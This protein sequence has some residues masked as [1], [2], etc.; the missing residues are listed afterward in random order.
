[1]SG[2][3]FSDFAMV[4]DDVSQSSSFQTDP[5]S[6]APPILRNEN[7]TI[8]HEFQCSLCCDIP[9]NPVITP[10]A[11]IFFAAPALSRHSKLDSNAPTIGNLSVALTYNHLAAC[12]VDYGKLYRFDVPK[13]NVHGLETWVTTR[14]MLVAASVRKMRART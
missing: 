3:A 14:H 2:Y 11:N 6:I 4:V 8:Q 9:F 12:C 1:M 10:S 5:S 7:E 13:Q